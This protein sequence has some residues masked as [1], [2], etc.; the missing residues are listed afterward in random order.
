MRQYSRTEEEAIRTSVLLR[1]WERSGFLGK[2]QTVDLA[3]ELHTDLRYTHWLFRLVLFFFTV[4]IVSASLWLI[5]FAFEINDK[6]SAALLSIGGAAVCF[7]AADLLVAH[8]RLYRFGVEEA[9]AVASAVLLT[10][11]VS[12]FASVDAF[13]SEALVMLCLCLVLLYER[14]GYLYAGMAAM[15]GTALIPFTVETSREMQRLS[16]ALIFACGF[17]LVR[18]KRLLWGED[19]PGDDYGVLQA[20]SWT[21]MYI[22]L[23]VQLGDSHGTIPFWFYWF[24]YATI[25]LLPIVGSWLAMQKKDRPLMQV[26]IALALATLATNKPYLAL[27][28][29]PWDPILLG[30]LSMGVAVLV[31]R[32]LANGT[33][34]QRYG[35]TAARLVA[36]NSKV[37]A[38]IATTSAVFQPDIHSSSTPQPQTNFGGGRSGGAGASGTF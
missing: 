6:T 17:V 15:I 11:G 26:N 24:T 14:F 20:L 38:V 37:M 10:G 1:Q 5:V 2:D 34:G 25:W 33:D 18:R 4:I 22:A 29:K 23:N 9:L 35:F 3:R 28:R 21:G 27:D 12:A 32:W 8:K 30:L 7:V 19:F 13:K 16:A 31:K 36:G